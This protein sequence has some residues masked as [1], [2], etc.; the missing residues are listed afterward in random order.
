VAE[1]VRVLV[2]GGLL[3]ASFITVFAPIRD[4]AKN[5]PEAGPKFAATPEELARWVRDGRW[6]AGEGS[7]F[8]DAWFVH[9]AE[10]VPLVEGAADLETLSLLAA[11]GVVSM[12]EEKVNQ[13]EGPLWDYWSEVNYR[14]AA[15]PSI[16]GGAEHLLYVG[17]KR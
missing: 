12:I 6:V 7:A 1:A 10:V 3:F 11:E 17:R 8:T 14:L 13:L 4:M 9:P 5:Y 2:P 15:D 16:L